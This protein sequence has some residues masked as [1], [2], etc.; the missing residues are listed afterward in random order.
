MMANADVLRGLVAV[1]RHQSSHGEMVVWSFVGSGAAA[2]A[3][4][5]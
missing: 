4:E 5:R 3:P 1:R 2:A